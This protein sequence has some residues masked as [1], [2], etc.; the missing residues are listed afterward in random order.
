M[1]KKNM[2]YLIELSKSNG[3][4]PLN[5]YHTDGNDLIKPICDHDINPLDNQ[6]NL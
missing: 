6:P 2:D 5:E 4:R 1:K 3:G